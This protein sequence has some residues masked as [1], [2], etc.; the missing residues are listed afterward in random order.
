MSLGLAALAAG[1]AI[2]APAQQPA[3]DAPAAAAPTRAPDAP[4]LPAW[5]RPAFT[6]D[7]VAHVPA[8]DLPPSQLSSPEAQAFQK[9]RAR[10]PAMVPG[11]GNTPI[12]VERQRL[13]AMLG[14]QAE[15]MR[16]LYPVDVEETAI[17]GIPV[18]IVTPHGR[19]PD[20]AR[21][22]IN[23]HGGAFTTCWEACSLLESV[24]VAALGGYR[25]VSVNYR[26]APEARH[27]SG[28]EDTVAVYRELLKRYPP[29]RIGLYG[30]SAGGALTAQIAAWLPAHKL[31]QVGAA[32][33]FGAG[34]VRFMA[35]DSAWIAASTDG[36]FPPPVLGDGKPKADMTHGYFAGADMND[37]VISPALHA[38]VIARFPPTL[39]IT[40]TRA[41][42]MSPAVVTNSA[43][44]KAGVPS[45][46]IVGEG[47]GHCY[48]YQHQLPEARDAH[49]AI[50]AFFRRNLN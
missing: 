20:P 1:L 33:I 46:L 17:A 50:V 27:P 34:G 48:I 26:M 29:R 28:I 5:P 7:G 9:L 13:A 15:A 47:M 25:V 3:P 23:V 11:G 2:P 10:M 37:P 45:T 43:L 36:S 6:A 21:V 41:M 40:G 42:D 49:A 24:P 12:A 14:P 39:I 35:G 32:G 22:L 30:C 4:A 31:P 19:K 8:F 38:D 16:K 44:I 18:R